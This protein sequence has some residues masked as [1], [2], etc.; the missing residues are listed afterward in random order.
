MRKFVIAIAAMLSLGTMSAHACCD[1]YGGIDNRDG[2]S[3]GAGFIGGS[4]IGS[5]SYSA[6]TNNGRAVN[7]GSAQSYQSGLV[8]G[9]IT[10][11]VGGG[12]GVGRATFDT[13]VVLTNEVLTTSYSDNQGA[14]IGYSDNFAAA[15]SLGV[16]GGDAYSETYEWDARY[17]WWRGWDRYSEE[18]ISEANAGGVGVLG[19]GTY[20]VSRT[21]LYRG[22]NDSVL[23]HGIANAELHLYGSAESDPNS[24]FADVGGGVWT[25]TLNESA[26][27]YENGITYG[28]SGAFGGGVM[29][30]N[31]HIEPV[32]EYLWGEQP[33]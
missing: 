24:A 14:A 21:G 10:D 13:R 26:S 22:G 20:S 19:A 4:V 30:E 16:A 28:E 23:N 25:Y 9:R 29:W 33:K 15:G 3:A 27:L 18:T 12:R 11:Q 2:A 31:G 1:W 6:S 7:A 32:P 5:R 8:T 17:C